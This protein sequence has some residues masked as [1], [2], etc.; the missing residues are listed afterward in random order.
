MKQSKTVWLIRGSVFV[1]PSLPGT[2]LGVGVPPWLPSAPFS[3]ACRWRNSGP[4][5]CLFY[6]NYSMQLHTQ[7]PTLKGTYALPLLPLASITSVGSCFSRPFLLVGSVLLL[8]LVVPSC[9][10]A[11][12][13]SSAAPHFSFFLLCQIKHIMS[14]NNK[15]ALLPCDKYTSQ[16]LSTRCAS[17]M[18][19]LSLYDI[20]PLGPKAGHEC[21]RDHSLPATLTAKTGGHWWRMQS[22]FYSISLLKSFQGLSAETATTADVIPA[23]MALKHVLSQEK[24]ADPGNQDD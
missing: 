24:T 7:T 19:Q 10:R 20:E 18:E 1:L 12:V 6:N 23:L 2:S 5:N 4:V 16:V 15:N 11:T 21:L 22:R 9:H 3:Q 17:K 14:S 13:A 8:L